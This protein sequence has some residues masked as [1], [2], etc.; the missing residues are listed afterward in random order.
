[1]NRTSNIIST[2]AKV[3][4]LAG[5]IGHA[6]VI[7]WLWYLTPDVIPSHE[8]TDSLILLTFMFASNLTA[9]FVLGWAANNPQTVNYPWEINE[10]NKKKQYWM[11]SLFTQAIRLEVVWLPTLISLNI[12]YSA[13]NGT[14]LFSMLWAALVSTVLIVSTVI[15]YLFCGSRH[16]KIS[17]KEAGM[18]K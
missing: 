2:C 7:F 10:S 15:F 3:L 5:L 12:V 9:F 17:V 14:N 1:M 18:R 16:S 13:V 11:A 8:K 4:A 6:L